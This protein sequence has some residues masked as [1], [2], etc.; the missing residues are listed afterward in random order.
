MYLLSHMWHTGTH[1]FISHKGNISEKLAELT[2][3]DCDFWVIS[4]DTNHFYESDKFEVIT[5]VIIDSDW[6][7]TTL[8]DGPVQQVT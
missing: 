6:L 4:R 5:E 3:L 8:D 1:I 2:D 7:K